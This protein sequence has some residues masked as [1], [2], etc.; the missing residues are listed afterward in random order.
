MTNAHLGLAAVGV[1]TLAALVTQF[2]QRVDYLITGT[3]YPAI[4]AVRDRLDL[5]QESFV[6]S[7]RLALMWGMP[8][9]IGLTLF[10][11]D[12]VA[13]G[14]GDQWKPAVVVLQVYGVTAALGMVAFN[15]D[16]YFRAVGNTR[17]IAVDS[18]LAAV[19]FLGTGIPLL[20][21]YGLPG[22][23]AAVVIQAVVDFACR[24]WYLSRLFHGFRYVGHALRSIA[25]TIPAVAAVLLVR[26]VEPGHRSL[27]WAVGELILY[28]ALTGLFT[29][30]FE[31]RLLREA[32]GYLRRSPEM[33]SAAQTS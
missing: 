32:V 9:G 6:K 11:A 23:A 22:F 16:A 27:A 26:L 7:N 8:F 29:L 1:V 15:W 14:L 5:L 31:G 13:Y 33:A 3:L 21:A 4:C 18:V 28:L 17:P 25:P 19:V 12:L 24:A 20:I 30:L 2:T 10:A